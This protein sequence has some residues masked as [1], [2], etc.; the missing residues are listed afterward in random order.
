M[1]L[2]RLFGSYEQGSSPYLLTTSPVS[3]DEIGRFGRKHIAEALCNG[4]ADNSCK[5]LTC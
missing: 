3:F 5:L 4:K 2:V 1:R